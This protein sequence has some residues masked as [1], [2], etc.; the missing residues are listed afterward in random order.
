MRLLVS[1][2]AWRQLFTSGDCIYATKIIKV[3][4][5]CEDILA[6]PNIQ[7]WWTLTLINTFVFSTDLISCNNLKSNW[8]IPYAVNTSDANSQ[9]IRQRND[10]RRCSLCLLWRHSSHEV[11]LVQ[12]LFF[13]QAFAA[14]NRRTDWAGLFNYL[15]PTLTFHRSSIEVS[16]HQMFSAR[17]QH[18]DWKQ[19]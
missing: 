11:N 15:L 14:V 8:N 13:L 5:T 16:V 4:F 17:S 10:V 9:V 18:H 19:N 2:L 12:G 6:E 1:L 7:V 3:V